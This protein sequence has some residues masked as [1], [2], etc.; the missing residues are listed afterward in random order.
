MRLQNVVHLRNDRDCSIIIT[1]CKTRISRSSTT[2]VYDDMFTDQ[3]K[4]AMKALQDAGPGDLEYN[5]YG[6]KCPIKKACDNLVD[7]ICFAINYAAPNREAHPFKV[8]KSKS[9]KKEPR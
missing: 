4:L 5:L 9:S 8:I 3:C 6:D 2:A 7:N 1:L